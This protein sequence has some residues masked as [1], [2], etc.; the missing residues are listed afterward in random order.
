MAYSIA[1][2]DSSK[3]FAQYSLDR[4]RTWRNATLPEVSVNDLAD[5]KTLQLVG[6]SVATLPHICSVLNRLEK[7]LR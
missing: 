2:G 5:R 3:P 6:M 7:Q 1:K 4:G